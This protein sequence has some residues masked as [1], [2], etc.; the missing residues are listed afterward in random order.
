MGPWTI[1]EVLPMCI[2]KTLVGEVT[3][4]RQIHTDLER[5][6]IHQ[7][8]LHQGA[9]C[10]FSSWDIWSEIGFPGDIA[11]LDLLRRDTTVHQE[12]ILR[13]YQAQYRRTPCLIDIRLC[14]SGQTKGTHIILHHHEPT[15]LQLPSQTNL[16][17]H[18]YIS[19]QHH[20]P[21]L[22]QGTRIS[23]RGWIRASI[24]RL[25][26]DLTRLILLTL[27][28][29]HQPL[30]KLRIRRLNQRRNSLSDRTDQE[31]PLQLQ[32]QVLYPAKTKK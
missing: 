7:L 8:D 32:P 30:I 28:K 17:H 20:T 26:L 13:E 6:L 24:G 29:T 9:Y 4:Y 19:L 23:K 31:S 18:I 14:N 22:H 2:E 15:A 3:T 10:L 5:H 27:A 11:L 16:D 25:N 1:G 12:R 21:P